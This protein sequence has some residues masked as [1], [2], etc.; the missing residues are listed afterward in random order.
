MNKVEFK[1]N[2]LNLIIKY[3]GK[4]CLIYNNSKTKKLILNFVIIFFVK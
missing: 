3:N 1:H 2:Y 4:Y